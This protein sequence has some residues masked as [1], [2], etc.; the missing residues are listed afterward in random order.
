M[1]RST[2]CRRGALRV[3]ASCRRSA[4]IRAARSG[5]WTMA[6]LSDWRGATAA[7]SPSAPSGPMVVLSIA[8][9]FSIRVISEMTPSCGK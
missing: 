5:V 6:R 2:R 3:Q 1:W 7:I 9:P 4:L 8:A